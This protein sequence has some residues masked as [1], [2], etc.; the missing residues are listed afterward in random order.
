MAPPM[1]KSST[2]DHTHPTVSTTHSEIYGIIILFPI[3]CH[4]NSHVA[5]S[6]ATF[7]VPPRA[8]MRPIVSTRQVVSFNV[9]DLTDLDAQA[10][11]TRTQG[12]TCFQLTSWDEKDN[13]RQ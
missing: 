10:R 3:F 11:H 9:S 7:V 2:Y 13:L 6:G 8:L 5:L 1:L 12:N 4:I